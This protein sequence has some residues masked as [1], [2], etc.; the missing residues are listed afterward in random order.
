M[1]YAVGRHKSGYVQQSMKIRSKSETDTDIA[2][3]IWCFF[4]K[5]CLVSEEWS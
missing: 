3:M 5:G 4:T 1:S 2:E